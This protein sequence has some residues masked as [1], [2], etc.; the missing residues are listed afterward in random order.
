MVDKEKVA[1]VFYHLISNAQ[2]AM[3]DDGE[4]DVVVTGNS[5]SNTQLVMIEDTGEGMEKSFI[6][7]RLFKP[8]DT[9]KEGKGMGIG[10]YQAR[11][12]IQNIGGTLTVDSAL[13]EGTTI[14]IT[15]PVLSSGS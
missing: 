5:D 11:D 15:I 7:E 3:G 9:T 6:E 1:N 14:V 10:V 2:Q 12:Y 13:G 8:F 4:I